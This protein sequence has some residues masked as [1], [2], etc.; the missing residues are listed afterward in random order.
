MEKRVGVEFENSA[1]YAKLV[2]DCMSNPPKLVKL[3]PVEPTVKSCPEFGDTGV[4]PAL[5]ILTKESVVESSPNSV[6]EVAPTKLFVYATW[7][8]DGSTP[9]LASPAA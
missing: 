6:V 4:P 1:A 5:P 7:T 3:A 2:P 9:K 8:T